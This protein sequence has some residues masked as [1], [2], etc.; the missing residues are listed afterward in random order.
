MHSYAPSL[1]MHGDGSGLVEP[2]GDHHRAVEA[3]QTGDLDQ[4]EA[5]VC[6]V[7]ISCEKDANRG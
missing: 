1:W 7:D 2:L 5:M 4:I 3:I 6:P